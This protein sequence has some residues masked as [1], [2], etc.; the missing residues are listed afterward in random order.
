LHLTPPPNAAIFL[1]PEQSLA[2]WKRGYATIRP[3][4][5]RNFLAPRARIRNAAGGSWRSRFGFEITRESGWALLGPRASSR[6]S[7][8]VA[9]RRAS[10]GPEG[11][12]GTSIQN[13]A[14]RPLI[15]RFRRKCQNKAPRRHFGPQKVFPGSV[16]PKRRPRRRWKHHPGLS[17]GGLKRTRGSLSPTTSRAANSARALVGA[18]F[19]EFAR[20]WTH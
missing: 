4:P 5:F 17:P 6:P 18:T 10:G 12:L 16:K 13:K 15:K 11:A 7:L 20:A 8:L 1:N 19:A 2:H 9:A 3:G 14:G